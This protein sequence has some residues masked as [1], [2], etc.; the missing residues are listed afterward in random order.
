[1]KL[2]VWS[3]LPPYCLANYSLSSTK[4]STERALLNVS[5]MNR[6][7][8]GDRELFTLTASASPGGARKSCTSAL[9][10]SLEGSFL[11]EWRDAAPGLYTLLYGDK[12]NWRGSREVK[13]QNQ[14]KR[15]SP[16]SGGNLWLWSLL[17]L[18]SDRFCVINWL[19]ML[20]CM[21]VIN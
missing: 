16:G 20:W 7:G 18:S 6:F 14:W 5:L 2:L 1:M 3:E 15:N 9:C 12:W 13:K 10:V 4:P 21:G 8:L 17:L 19:H 11:D